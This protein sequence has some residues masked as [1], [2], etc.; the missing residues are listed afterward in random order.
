MQ[1]GLLLFFLAFG[2]LWLNTG[3]V[4]ATGVLYLRSDAD[5]LLLPERANL[6]VRERDKEVYETLVHLI[7]LLAGQDRYIMAMPDCPEVVFLSRRKNPTRVLSEFLDPT[8]PT[9][10]ELLDHLTSMGVRVVVLNSRP[11][12]SRPVSHELYATLT[13]VYSQYVDVGWFRVLWKD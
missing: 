5:R 10:W 1:I 13:E 6:R 7:D 3:T 11:E 12:F 9:P 2:V 4:Q 8:P